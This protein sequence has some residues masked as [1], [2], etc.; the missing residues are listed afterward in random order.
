MM[1]EICDA[2]TLRE[3]FVCVLRV[4]RNVKRD[5]YWRESEEMVQRFK[6]REEE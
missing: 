1:E 5:V 6:E 3:E 2:F 4:G